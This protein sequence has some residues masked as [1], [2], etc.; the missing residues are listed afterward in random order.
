MLQPFFEL[1]GN[2]SRIYEPRDH[3][4]RNRKGK[5]GEPII[6]RRRDFDVTCEWIQKFDHEPTKTSVHFYAYGKMSAV[7]DDLQIG[8]R[9]TVSFTIDGFEWDTEKYGL[10]TYNNL[11]A[12][13][14][15]KTGSYDFDIEEWRRKQKE[16][17]GEDYSE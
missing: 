4:L 8:D 9:V 5:D 13:K 2:V 15:T 16:M 11:Y 3:E 6:K 12:R 14:I 1:T 10:W 7:V 17:N